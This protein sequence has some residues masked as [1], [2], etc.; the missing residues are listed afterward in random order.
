MIVTYLIYFSTHTHTHFG[1]KGNPGK[2]KTPGSN[3]RGTSRGQ[4]TLKTLPFTLLCAFAICLVPECKTKPIFPFSEPEPIGMQSHSKL[5]RR[6]DIGLFSWSWPNKSQEAWARCFLQDL[7][8]EFHARRVDPPL[9]VGVFT[10]VHETIK[11]GTKLQMFFLPAR[12]HQASLISG[13]S[14]VSARF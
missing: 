5:I 12:F 1:C 3:H 8:G 11:Y 7:F 10:P 14:G 6:C 13:F 9:M 2:V 4:G